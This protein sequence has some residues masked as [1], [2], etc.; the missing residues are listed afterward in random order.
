M[1]VRKYYL[2]A[3]DEEKMNSRV[4]LMKHSRPGLALLL[5][6][7]LFACGGSSGTDT[8]TGTGTETSKPNILLIIADDMGLDATPGYT[9]GSEKPTM[10]VLTSLSANGITFENVWV[11]PLCTPTRATILTGKYGI[12]S[13]VTGVTPPLNGVSTSD[14]SIQS[15]LTSNASYQSAVIGKWHLSNASNGGADNPGLMGVDHYEGLLS[16][17]HSD[18]SNWTLT[19]NGQTSTAQEYSTSYFTDKAID[20][21]NDQQDPWFLWLS[22]T[23]PHTPFHL[24]PL[25]LHTRD[26]LSGS[27]DDIQDNPR[28]YYFAALEALDTEIGRLLGTIDREN[29]IVIFIGD[30]GTPARVIQ[31]PYSRDHSKGSVYQGGV[32]VPMVI[33]GVGVS[34]NGERDS[35]LINSTDLYATIADIAG[36]ELTAIHDSQSFKG[37]LT[38]TENQERDFL[39]A[40]IEGT[41]NAWAI[42]DSQYKLITQEEG[43]QELYDLFVD[44]YEQNDLTL[45][46]LTQA[47]VLA[48]TKLESLAETVR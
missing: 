21:V 26:D 10:P 4:K 23:A 5:C 18:Y 45:G 46:T 35:A 14:T 24:P 33:S 31:S 2:S 11:N 8:G 1:D 30:N 39:Y 44:P 16:G 42:R 40:E 36:T 37:L 27:E 12:N 25:D 38:G 22:Y 29:T 17:A 48:K 34:R 32:H 20:W 9:V 3:N 47:Q 19:V 43:F 6:V 7:F 28:D 41:T 13:G 15:Y